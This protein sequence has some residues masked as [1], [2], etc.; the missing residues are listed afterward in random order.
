MLLK[1]LEQ[2]NK[3]FHG[4][5]VKSND[6]KE[7]LILSCRKEKNATCDEKSEKDEKSFGKHMI[8]N[9]CKQKKLSV[10]QGIKQTVDFNYRSGEVQP[11][12]YSPNL[13]WMILILPITYQMDH[14]G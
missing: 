1:Q 10:L 8:C 12:F 9:F 5:K 3:Y 4:F 13:L 6:K 11:I 14:I 2:F 7:N